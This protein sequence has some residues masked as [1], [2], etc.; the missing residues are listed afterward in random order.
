MNVYRTILALPLLLPL[1]ARP[2]SGQDLL[3]TLSYWEMSFQLTRSAEMREALHVTADQKKRIEEMRA[4][5]EWQA[6]FDSHDDVQREKERK[7]NEKIGNQIRADKRLTD[8]EKKDQ[9]RKLQFS[10]LKKTMSEKRYVSYTAGNEEVKQRL[11]EV[12]T[13][14]QMDV[15]Y[16][17][18]L[19]AKYSNGSAPFQDSVF[20][21]HCGIPTSWPSER[22]LEN[23]K[24][25]ESR[26]N[27][28]MQKAQIDACR[29]VVDALPAEPRNRM[30]NLVGKFYTVSF[31]VTPIDDIPSNEISSARL[32]LDSQPLQKEM[33]LT[34]RQLDLLRE[35]EELYQNDFQALAESKQLDKGKWI[36]LGKSLEETIK[37]CLDERQQS[38]LQQHMHLQA[39]LQDLYYPLKENRVF[40]YLNL[41][42]KEVADF[43]TVIEQQQT[44][45]RELRSV[46][47]RK[48]F[49]EVAKM[50]PPAAQ[51]KVTQTF[52][53]VWEITTVPQLTW[54]SLSEQ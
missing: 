41:D 11:N 28:S 36:E 37:G 21:T 6:V 19:R 50:V 39:F 9:I 42:T 7:Q 15:L 4:E 51:N 3:P 38:Q 8:A 31:S 2:T 52:K 43:R 45:L 13:N 33:R 54:H 12:L 46:E 53:G 17:T 10:T 23:L 40:K 34:S 49:N 35:A 22:E 26:L 29:A 32:I 48:A 44:K 14:E 25:I 16:P 30:I 20:T 18:M 47:D 24:R 5:P 1:L 27:A